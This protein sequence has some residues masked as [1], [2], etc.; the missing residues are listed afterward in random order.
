MMMITQANCD[1]LNTIGDIGAVDS[2]VRI[3]AFNGM[4]R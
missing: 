3:R 2:C 1:M 4:G